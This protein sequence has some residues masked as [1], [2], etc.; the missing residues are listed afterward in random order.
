[1]K[2]AVC[3]TILSLSPELKSLELSQTSCL[4]KCLCQGFDQ[5]DNKTNTTPE[6]IGWGSFYTMACSTAGVWEVSECSPAQA[7]SSH[8]RTLSLR[9]EK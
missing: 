1:M 6:P 8:R 2:E 7:I 3:S 4:V 9:Q 5:N